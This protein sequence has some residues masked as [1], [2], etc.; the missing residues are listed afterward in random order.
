[1]CGVAAGKRGPRRRFARQKGVG[2]A[3]DILVQCVKI[4]VEARAVAGFPH[5]PAQG[6]QEAVQHLFHDIA[7]QIPFLIVEGFLDLGQL[8][9]KN[10]NG[11][12]RVFPLT[13]ELEAHGGVK[14]IKIFVRQPFPSYQRV[15]GQAA[16]IVGLQMETFVGGHIVHCMKKA[17]TRLL[18][19]VHELGPTFDEGRGLKAAR[20]FPVDAFYKRVQAFLE[21]FA[22]A[23]RKGK[24]LRTILIRE[25]V[26]IDKIGRCRGLARQ[27]PQ[28]M[29]QH[30]AAPE[31]RFS[32][33][34]DIVACAADVQR[35]IKSLHG[36][37]LKG[38]PAVTA[39]AGQGDGAAVVPGNPGRIEGRVQAA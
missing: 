16:G 24:E 21:F 32:G 17:G 31:I 11:A 6:R 30:M 23:C 35:K 28:V 33:Q 39:V 27:R 29:E 36:P 37:W 7:F 1:M 20:E 15:Q 13:P 22:H 3:Q 38:I 18:V 19:G 34:I 4:V 12:G 2:V 14:L 10:G 8:A 5:F 25:I 9:H 26:N